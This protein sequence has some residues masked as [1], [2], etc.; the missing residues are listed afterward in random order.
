MFIFSDMVL[1]KYYYV[2]HE[3]V[4]QERGRP[5]SVERIPDSDEEVFLWGHSL[6]LLAKLLRMYQ[7]LNFSEIRILVYLHDYPKDCGQ[8]LVIKMHCLL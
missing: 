1:P 4:E 2:A 6:Y 3:G 7:L 5:G 8:E